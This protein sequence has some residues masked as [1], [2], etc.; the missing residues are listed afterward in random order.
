MKPNQRCYAPRCA[1]FR[2]HGPL[3]TLRTHDPAGRA[4]RW[5]LGRVFELEKRMGTFHAA[6]L[7]MR[8]ML[9]N[10]NTPGRSRSSR[11]AFSAWPDRPDRLISDPG[12]P[13]ARTYHSKLPLLEAKPLCFAAVVSHFN[14]SLIVTAMLDMSRRITGLSPGSAYA[15]TG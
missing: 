8:H 15:N 4:S 13:S 14:A 7:L 3:A 1:T 5:R 10:P 9:W 12:H 6:K 11:G 2:G